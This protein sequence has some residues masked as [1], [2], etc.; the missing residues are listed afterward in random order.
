MGMIHVMIVDDDA[1]DTDFLKA[2]FAKRLDN[3]RFTECQTGQLAVNC[4]K[5]LFANPLDIPDIIFLDL[6]MPGMPGLQALR[7]IKAQ[8]AFA[9][10]PVMII[11][12]SSLKAEKDQTLAAGGTRFYI[13]PASLDA[14]DMIVE[15]SLRYLS[16]KHMA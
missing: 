15:D 2:A 12:T 3:I 14:Y 10:I 4:L 11:S 8:P 16:Q 1:D 13:K 5:G 7:E 6:H 9:H